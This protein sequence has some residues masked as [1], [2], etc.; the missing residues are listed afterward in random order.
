VAWFLFLSSTGHTKGLL[1]VVTNAFAPINRRRMKSLGRIS[2]SKLDVYTEV[3]LQLIPE[4][5][6]VDAESGNSSGLSLEQRKE[7]AEKPIYLRRL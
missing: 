4:N 6:T 2:K 3:P 5:A 1:S 7:E